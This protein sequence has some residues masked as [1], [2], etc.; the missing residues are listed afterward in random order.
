MAHIHL[1]S[2]SYI[3]GD[4]LAKNRLLSYGFLL[5]VSYFQQGSVKTAFEYFKSWMRLFV[6]FMFQTLPLIYFADFKFN[7]SLV[8]VFVSNSYLG[9]LQ[10][11]LYTFLPFILTAPCK[12]ILLNFG[13]LLSKIVYIS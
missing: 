2:C 12:Y 9:F 8:G 3:G 7:V 6:S 5:Y 1:N 13:L 11:V 10:M 4:S